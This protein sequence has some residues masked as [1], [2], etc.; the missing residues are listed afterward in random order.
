[1]AQSKALQEERLMARPNIKPSTI[2]NIVLLS[3]VVGAVFAFFGITPENFW[4]G[5]IELFRS[6]LRTIASFFEWGATYIL[7]GAAVVLPIYAIIFI[8]RYIKGR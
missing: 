3:L 6:A 8:Y 7:L 1:M 4:T 2:F 5:I